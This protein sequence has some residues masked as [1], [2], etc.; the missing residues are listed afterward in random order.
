MTIS[1]SVSLIVCIIGGVVYFVAKGEG[2]EL[3]RIAF[4][5]GLMWFVYAMGGSHGL[6]LR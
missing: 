6:S 1:G 3:G 2:K 5:V 4:F